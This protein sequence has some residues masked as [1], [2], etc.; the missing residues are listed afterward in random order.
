[1]KKPI[2]AITMGDPSGIGPEITLKVFSQKETYEICHPFVIGDPRV[3]E[4]T[5]QTIGLHLQVNPITDISE[6]RFLFSHIDILHP[7]GLSLQ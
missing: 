3:M 4:Q 6:G 7:E 5:S 1:V 2:I